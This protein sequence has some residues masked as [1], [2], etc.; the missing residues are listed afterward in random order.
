MGLASALTNSCISQL[1]CAN[2]D[3]IYGEAALQCLLDP[4]VA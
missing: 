3:Q 1:Q 4:R 2:P